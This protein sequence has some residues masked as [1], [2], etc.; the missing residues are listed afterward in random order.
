MI[1]DCPTARTRPAEK[2]GS[3]QAGYGFTKIYLAIFVEALAL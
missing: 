1:S 2:T 3:V